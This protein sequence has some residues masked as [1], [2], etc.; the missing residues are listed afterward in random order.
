M[1]SANRRSKNLKVHFDLPEC[2][3]TP[4]YEG[5]VSSISSNS[6]TA[7]SSPKQ[8]PTTQVMDRTGGYDPNRIPSSVFSATATNTTNLNPMEW[9]ATSNESL[10]SLHINFS[11]EMNPYALNKSEGGGD[12]LCGIDESVVSLDTSE[13]IRGVVMEETSDK[14]SSETS[15]DEEEEESMMVLYTDGSFHFPVYVNIIDQI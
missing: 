14:V 8:C 4:N 10:F 6:S 13:E 5:S 2:E 12:K 15:A 1:A 11:K 3:Y 9:S 7:S